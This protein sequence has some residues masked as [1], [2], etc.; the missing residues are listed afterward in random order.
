MGRQV[1]FIKLK[2]ATACWYTCER[3]RH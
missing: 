3:R 2:L 1:L